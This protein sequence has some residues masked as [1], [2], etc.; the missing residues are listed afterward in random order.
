M[1]D[2]VLVVTGGASGIGL[3]SAVAMAGDHAAIALLDQNP[4]TLAAA[5]ADRAFRDSPVHT[6][7]CDVSDAAGQKNLAATVEREVGPVG[8]VVTSAGIL[9]NP[10][11]VLDMDLEEHDRVWQVNYHGTLH[12]IRAFAPAMSKRGCGAIVTIGSINSFAALPLPAYCPAKTALMRLTEILAV[13]L[14]RHG[15][16]INGVAPTFVLTPALKARIEAGDRDEKLI[17]QSG[18]LDMFVYPEQIASVIR[19]LC[20]DAAAAITGTMLPVDAGWQAAT[21]YK[22]FVGGV[23]WKD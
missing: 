8:A 17:R 13:E 14:G 2:S 21:T 3:A 1:Q 20:S 18:A 19:F 11:T 23:P 12:T 10:A 15:V 4:E 5:K 9:H 16:R 7:Q 22:S 6:F